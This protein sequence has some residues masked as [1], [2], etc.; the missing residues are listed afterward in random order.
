MIIKWFV[1]LLLPVIFPIA[2]YA[3][4]I[5]SK[6][7]GSIVVDE[8]TSIYD[9]DTFRVNINSWPAIVWSAGTPLFANA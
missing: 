8:V 1:S 9:G 4:D 7:Y 3:N 5:L 2:V 6:N